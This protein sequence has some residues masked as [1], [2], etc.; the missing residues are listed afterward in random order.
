MHLFECPSRR[1][2]RIISDKNSFSNFEVIS[3]HFVHKLFLFQKSKTRKHF[4]T[5]LTSFEQNKGYIF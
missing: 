2:T 4:K 1:K 5:D 3:R